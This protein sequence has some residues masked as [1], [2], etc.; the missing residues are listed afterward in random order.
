[1]ALDITTNDDRTWAQKALDAKDEIWDLYRKYGTVERVVQETGIPRQF[2][3]AVVDELPLRQIYRRTGNA[4]TYD[5]EFLIEC[6]R[7]AAKLCGEPLTIPA[8]RE[9][10]PQHE[11]PADLTITKAFGNWEAACKAA[12]VASNASQGPRRGSYTEEDCLIALRV[13]R[14]DVGEIPSYEQYSKWATANR[15]PSGATVRVKVGPWREAL[16]KAY[17]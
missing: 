5:Q 10:A 4:A 14:A 3:G 8:Y 9:V 7:E 2:V 13:C 11:W 16:K 17:G 1:M 6:L 12:G 15:R